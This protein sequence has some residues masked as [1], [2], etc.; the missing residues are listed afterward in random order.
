[1]NKYFIKGLITGTLIGFVLTSPRRELWLKQLTCKMK[2]MA[3]RAVQG[4]GA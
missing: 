2:A 4:G 1:M 3:K